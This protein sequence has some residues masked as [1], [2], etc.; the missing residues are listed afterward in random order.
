VPKSRKLIKLVKKTGPLYS[1]SA[2]ISSKQPIK[3]TIDA[4]TEFEHNLDKIFVVKG[5]QH[6][7]YPS[8]IV[9]FDNLTVVR[10]G[11]VDGRQIIKTLKQRIE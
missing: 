3:N 7:P 8:T 10:C 1:S 11:I 4:F 9:D 2:N 5:K 6:S